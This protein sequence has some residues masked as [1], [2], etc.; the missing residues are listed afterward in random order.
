[1]ARECGPPRWRSYFVAKQYCVYILAS[2]RNGTLYVGVTGNLAGR[3]W[4][5][6]EGLIDGFTKRYGVKKLVHFECFDDVRQA[7]HRE[8]RLKKW[9][10]EWKINLIQ[11][12][13]VEWKD[14]YDRLFIF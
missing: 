7:I 14:L 9:K 2:R 10:R 13:N 4:E 11:S 3:V 5:H 8:K 1:M 6:R 12:N